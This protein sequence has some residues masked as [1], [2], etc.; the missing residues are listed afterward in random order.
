[1]GETT[2]DRCCEGRLQGESEVLELTKDRSG[3]PGSYGEGRVLRLFSQGA[4]R[5]SAS[6]GG[7]GWGGPAAVMQ[8]PEC[9]AQEQ[10]LPCDPGDKKDL[11]QE[12]DLIRFIH[13][14]GHSSFCV[15]KAGKAG[16]RLLENLKAE[17]H[18]DLNESSC[19]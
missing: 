18:E 17:T 5:Q 9:R 7:C 11:K 8:G 10:T 16:Q 19:P 15:T 3:L 12:T 14:Q 13:L 6:A 1:M 4:V 2:C